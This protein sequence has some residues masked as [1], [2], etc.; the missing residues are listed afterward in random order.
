MLTSFVLLILLATLH[1]LL[2]FHV[3]RSNRHALENRAFA[4]FALFTGLW[5]VSIAVAHHIP[6]STLVVT[7]LTFVLGAILAFTFLRMAFIT[8][9]VPSLWLRLGPLALFLTTAF[10][11][12]ALTSYV[13]VDARLVQAG[14]IVVYGVAHALFASHVV[15]YFAV[16]FLLLAS[17]YRR[18][19][20]LMRARLRCLIMSLS[21]PILGAVITNLLL[22]L[23]FNRSTV[24]VYGPVFAVVFFALTVHGFIR[25]RLFDVTL[26]ITHSATSMS[27]LLVSLIPSLVFLLAC[28]SRLARTF[29]PTEL[30]LF[31]MAF[32][33]VGAVTPT[34]RQMTG[35]A[36]DSYVFRTRPDYKGALR[37]ASRLLTRVLSLNS[38]LRLIAKTIADSIGTTSVTVFLLRGDGSF[39]A[40]CN[41]SSRPETSTPLVLP[42]SIQRTL[43][44][45]KRPIILDGTAGGRHEPSQGPRTE[46]HEIL[47]VPVV[48]G[49][50]IIGVVALGSK[51]SGDPFFSQDIDLLSTLAN[52]AGVAIKNAQLYEQVVLINEYLQNI[53]GTIESGVVA[54]TRAGHVTIFNRA[55]EQL[56]GL[57]VDAI[58]GR[59]IAELPA[60][61]RQPLAATAEDGQARVLAE[62][63]LAK[64]GGSALPV[65]CLTSPLRDPAGGLLG[66]VAVFSDLTALKQLEMERRRAERLAYFEV[67]AAGIGH[68]IKNP[69]VAI[70]TFAQLLPRKFL[71]E[72]FRQE[73]ARVVGREIGRME[74]LAG[75]LRAL[76][77]PGGGPHRALDLRAPIADA[78]ELLQPRLDEKGIAIRW[79]PGPNPSQVQGDHAALEQLFLNLI[80]NALDAMEAGGA[81]SV[82]LR[83]TEGRMIV[84][85]EDTGPGIPDEFLPRMF[86][87]F[88]TTKLHGSGL[89][90]AICASIANAHR[91]RIHASNVPGQRGAVFTI[92]FP[93]E[94]AASTPVKA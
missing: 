48:S 25:Y 14:L 8:A 82:R 28:W 81:L 67:L 45:L 79:T 30:L 29:Q 5:T 78:V 19:F 42:D 86:E 77:R 61:L 41:E 24:G 94:V 65:L 22:P 6:R 93:A 56:T 33:L 23:L 73:F 88:V 12:L 34:I 35:R 87:P 4:F 76:A 17:S 40:A 70:K 80:G 2:S 89:G 27:A 46:P 43:T 18:A 49:D 26:F 69:L 85:V 39:W 51:R 71:D 7:R 92:E 11:V 15:L 50:E 66:A 90:L 47:F 58:L 91:A 72:Q 60:A 44:E 3:L 31:L 52:Q 57:D 62:V 64:P 83:S 74:H 54:I 38:L 10:S 20:G 75:R 1:W 59:A 53:V 68:E 32:V 16:G 13:V 36:L 84:E 55:A 9:D 37:Q 63:E 21:L